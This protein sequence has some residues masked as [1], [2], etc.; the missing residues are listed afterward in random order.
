MVI[1]YQ[2]DSG[3]TLARDAMPPELEQRIARA[4]SLENPEH[5]E[6]LRLKLPV[7]G[8]PSHL[9]F[10]DWTDRGLRVPRGGL[11]TLQEITPLGAVDDR[12]TSHDRTQ[13]IDAPDLRPYQSRAVE[14]MIA[15]ES[16]V[17]V[18]PCGG[19]KTRIA[20]GALARLGQPALVIVHTLDLAEQ[21]RRELEL[22]GAEPG[23]IG[24]GKLQVKPVT[25]ALVQ[26]LIRWPAG[27]LDQF[28][29]GFGVLVV[30]ECHHVPSST[31]R[32]VVDCSP[33]RYRWGLSATPTRADGLT[34]LLEWFIGPTLA[35][36]SHV[37][38]MDGG[39]LVRPEVRTVDTG[40]SFDYRDRADYPRLLEALAT[41]PVRTELIA[42][43]VAREAE[44][45]HLCLVLSSRID[46]CQALASA[47]IRLGTP[48]EL[49]TGDTAKARRGE[50]LGLARAGKV[51]VL[52]ATTLADEG[53]DLPALSRVFLAFP[54]RSLGRTQQRL[55]R[56]MRTAPDKPKAVL[57]DFVDR[58]V[59]VLRGHYAKRRRV[60]TEILG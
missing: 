29:A 9:F 26:S 57:F 42:R 35:E 28:L 41:D 56:L 25:V 38:L 19:G 43:A 37:E 13:Q 23:I 45:G 32:R 39:V 30:D 3:I 31:F 14:Q 36:V 44:S 18:V 17:V 40:F 2:L 54:G 15:R 60:Y 6:R 55:G 8:V 33:S 49:L 52:V 10:A 47:I 7:W 16:G 50:L 58:S 5:A 21:W 46:H 51:H 24:G 22:V 1:A 27:Q 20:I 59:G 48:A 12:R 34:P 11:G 4:F 53:L